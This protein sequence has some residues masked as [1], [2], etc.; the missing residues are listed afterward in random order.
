MDHHRPPDRQP[1]QR[2][3]GAPIH[4]GDGAP[5]ASLD[6]CNADHGSNDD[7]CVFHNVTRGSISTECDQEQPYTITTG[8]Y[9]FNTVYGGNIQVR[10][11]TK[12]ADPSTYS[13]AT[14]AYGAQPGWSFAAG[15][16]SVNARNLLIAW[17][18][19]IHAPSAPPAQ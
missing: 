16:G 5:L 15:L 14:K 8:C 9:F 18:A 4:H 10:L 12:M 6:V 7:G 17:R 11:T 2:G 1:L 3:T 13:P 19:F